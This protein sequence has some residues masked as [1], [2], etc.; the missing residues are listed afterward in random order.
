LKLFLLVQ[1]CTD[2]GWVNVVEVVPSVL[3]T[4][5]NVI[6]MDFLAS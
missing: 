2:V 5:L 1:K 4:V 3:G 6:F